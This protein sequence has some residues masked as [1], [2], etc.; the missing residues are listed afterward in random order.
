[1]RAVS[2]PVCGQIPNRRTRFPARPGEPAPFCDFGRAR[3]G[4]ASS[5]RCRQGPSA[6]GKSCRTGALG[7]GVPLAHRVQYSARQDRGDGR[8]G[9][10]QG[11]P[12]HI[13]RIRPPVSGTEVNC[14]P[15]RCFD[16]PST[17]QGPWRRYLGRAT[18][19]A[20][21][22]RQDSQDSG[23]GLPRRRPGSGRS[24]TLLG[25]CFNHRVSVFH[26]R[27][28]AP[29]CRPGTTKKRY[30]DGLLIHFVYVL[31]VSRRG[32]RPAGLITTRMTQGMH[33]EAG[34]VEHVA[35]K[36]R[37]ESKVS[38]SGTPANGPGSGNAGGRA[39][40][41]STMQWIRAFRSAVRINRFF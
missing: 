26:V 11:R 16:S 39:A 15:M 12:A 19:R 35:I 21:G 24:L 10:A 25:Y 30:T 38:R 31:D 27:R 9:L 23:L 7:R 2:G 37:V 17:R 1:M 40:M 29:L 33:Y 34:A 4:A 18:Q 14:R 28:H 3:C 5:A 6:R 36:D 32:S 13:A 20:P 22:F 8:Q 41:S